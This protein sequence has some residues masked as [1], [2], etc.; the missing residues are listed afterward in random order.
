LRLVAGQ[1]KGIVS[2]NGF[3]ADPALGGDT[4]RVAVGTTVTW[5]HGSDEPHT[6]TFLAGGPRPQFVVPQPESADLPPMFNPI[7]YFP[8]PPAGPYD[9]KSYLNSGLIEE[10]GTFSVT[11]GTPGRF[12][13]TCIIHPEMNGVIDVVQPGTPGIT[14]QAAVDDLAA[15]HM[16]QVHDAQ[17]AAIMAT[18]QDPRP[19]EDT[20]GTTWF[21]RS[22]TDW[23]AGH[24]D[25]LG[26]MPQDL[27]VRRGDT[28]VWYV[29]HR[30]PHTVTFVPAGE[31]PP[32]PLKP[33]L[34]PDGTPRLVYDIG[35]EMVRPGP[36][37][38]PTKFFNSGLF[39]DVNNQVLGGAGA[40]S[41][42]FDTPG[43]YEYFCYLHAPM[44]MVGTITVE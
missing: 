4:A 36:V 42:T 22:G 23:R 20:N 21:V 33:G 16:A 37:H 2:M 6:V 13:Y 5:V 14:T 32:P 8:V 19:L 18:R 29:D 35:A 41:L 9:G 40:W 15:R 31:E 1:G 34:S 7:V 28:V 39:G 25:V 3:V 10:Q 24:L 44:G 30:I 11:F 26:F 12:P 17:V 27:T 38:D 43:T